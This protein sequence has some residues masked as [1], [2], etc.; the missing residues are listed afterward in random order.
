MKSKMCPICGTGKLEKKVFDKDFEY[1]GHKITVP[2]YTVHECDD[3]EES[4]VDPQTLK[5][6]G[7]I[8]K[9]AAKK[10][11]GFLTG[12]EVR[13]IRKDL[14][15]TQDNLSDILGGGHKCIA[16]YESEA[17]TQT[18]AMDNLLRIIRAIP[19][20]IHVLTGHFNKETYNLTLRD[21]YFP[22]EKNNEEIY[23]KPA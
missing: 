9:E 21:R 14:Q 7:K 23:R 19:E 5:E 4:I 10:I 1:K 11:D 16:K 22:G 20:A 8:I 2:G 12:W 17:L 18:R 15:M 3:C 6:S 13:A